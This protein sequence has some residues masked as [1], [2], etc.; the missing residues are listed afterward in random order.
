GALLNS[1]TIVLTNAG[2]CA[3]NAT[4]NLGGATL[5]NKGTIEALWPHGGSRTIEGS[6]VNEKTM[7]I[8]NQASQPLTVTGGYTQ[9]AKGQLKDT[10]AGAT[11]FGR[12]AV[13]GAVALA[14]K[15]AL[16]QKGFTGKSGE[17]FAIITG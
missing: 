7:T 16:K 13:A 8:A 6:V 17:T 1:G 15:L 11:N 12:L 14:G 2:G 9:G 3:N 10:I 4:L 5:E